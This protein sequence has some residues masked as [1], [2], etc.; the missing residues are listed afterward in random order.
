MN[1]RQIGLALRN[2]LFSSGLAADTGYLGG[3]SRLFP[4][5]RAGAG[6]PTNHM[7]GYGDTLPS[8]EAGWAVG[9]LFILLNAGSTTSC[10]YQNTGTATSCTFT[11]AQNVDGTIAN[12]LTTQNITVPTGKTL[13]VTDLDAL[14]IAG[15]KIPTNFNL[16]FP[17]NAT[18][19]AA[20]TDVWVADR[21]YQVTKIQEIHSV[22][23]SGGANVKIRKIT[24]TSAPGAAASGTVKELIDGTNSTAS[25][26]DITSTVNTFKAAAARVLS[27]TASDLQFAADN[28]LA[29]FPA[30]VPTG[31]IGC[32]TVTLKAI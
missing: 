1:F 31:Y 15:I 29:F 10:L 26:L 30:G 4:T 3:N 28:R 9:A 22:V 19:L 11:K 21:A 25:A 24:D 20:A 17:F 12:N 16:A 23:S 18:S 8:A 13:T 5:L 14:T 27:L 6:N 2:G 7:I 32:I